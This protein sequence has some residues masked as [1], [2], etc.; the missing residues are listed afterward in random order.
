MSSCYAFCPDVSHDQEGWTGALHTG[1]SAAQ[2]AQHDADK[3]NH[4]NP[5]H[6]AEVVCN[7]EG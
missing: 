1:S 3:H 5:E 4:E 2:E 7:E 6:E